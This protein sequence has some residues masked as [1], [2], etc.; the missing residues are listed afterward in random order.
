MLLKGLLEDQ[1]FWAKSGHL[2]YVSDHGTSTGT[3]NV[4]AAHMKNW[5]KILQYL[6]WLYYVHFSIWVFLILWKYMSNPFEPCSYL[7]W[8]KRDETPLLMHMNYVSF[9][10][11][12][13]GQVTHICIS[14]LT[15]IGLDNRL[16]LGRR[17]AIIWTSAGILLIRTLGTNFSEILS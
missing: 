5:D 2:S 13:W 3:C 8:C 10:L 17:Q 14:R 16:L 1:N 15:I 9:A 11:T 6:G 12:H 4:I 7:A